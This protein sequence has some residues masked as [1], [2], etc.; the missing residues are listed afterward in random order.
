MI[1][2]TFFCVVLIRWESLLPPKKWGSI[3]TTS[4]KTVR[5]SDLDVLCIIIDG[6][7]VFFCEQRS[8]AVS[9]RASKGLPLL[10]SDQ[11]WVWAASDWGDWQTQMLQRS[12]ESE[13]DENHDR[14]CTVLRGALSLSLWAFTCC[15]MLFLRNVWRCLFLHGLEACF[16][17]TDFKAWSG[18]YTQI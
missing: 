14:S 3:E 1:L 10:G 4:A 13:L 16:L 15:D 18:V 9:F 7:G 17:G 8:S 11:I 5:L 6:F 12:S 2:F